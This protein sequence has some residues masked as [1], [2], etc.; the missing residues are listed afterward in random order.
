MDNSEQLQKIN[1][2]LQAALEKQ[3]ET[4]Q[5]A[6]DDLISGIDSDNS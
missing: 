1:E 3:V 2:K 5:S 6:T 4:I